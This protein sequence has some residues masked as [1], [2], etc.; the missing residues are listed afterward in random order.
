MVDWAISQKHIVYT[1]VAAFCAVGIIGLARMNK[2]EFPSFTIKQGVVVGVYPGAT[3]Q[4]VE[5]RLTGRLEDCLL[6]IPEVTRNNLR[7]V[8]KDGM[9]FIYTDLNC[10]VSEKNEVWGRIKQKI[11]EQKVSL[12]AGVLAVM[13]LDDFN[14]QSSMMI[15][16]ESSDKGY[17]ELQDYA[18]E[19]CTALRR[20]PELAKVQVLGTQNEEIAVILDREKLSEYGIDPSVLTLSWQ[21]ESLPIPGG[22]FDSAEATAPIHVWGNL[23][24]ENEVAEK[25]VYADPLG[26]LIRLKDIATITRRFEA[27]DDFVSFNGHSCLILSVE[28]RPNHDIVAFGEKVHKV[29]DDYSVSLPESV[30]LSCI[31]DQSKI[32]GESVFSFL[33]DLL[34]SMLLVVLVMLTLFPLKSALIAGTGV[35][36]C[37]AI[38]IAIMYCCRMD[39]NTVTLAAL[40]VVL[41]MIVDNSIITMDGYMG[42]LGDGLDRRSAARSSIKELFAP[43]FAATLAISAMLFPIKFLITGYLGDFVKLFP[44]VLAIAMFVSLIYAVTVIPSLELKYIASATPEGDTLVSRLQRRFFNSLQNAYSKAENFCFRHPALTIGTG[45]TV[46]LLGLF[47]FTRLNVQMMPKAARDFFA[48]ELEVEGGHGIDRAKEVADSLTVML[49]SDSRVESVTSFVGS[50]A[51]RFTATY[52]PITPDKTVAQLIVNTESAK[53]TESIIRE[54][55]NSN[56]H[57][58]PDVSIRYKQMDYQDVEAPIV[59]TLK[60]NDREELRSYADSIKSFMMGMDRQLKWIHSTADNVQPVFRVELDDYEASRLGVNK[61]AL[62]LSMSGIY[63]GQPLATVWEGDKPIGVNLYTEGVGPDMNYSQIGSVMVPTA[64]PGVSVP[65][66]QVASI[67]PDWTCRNLEK[68]SGEET[69]SI[70]ADLKYGE[71]QPKAMKRI[72]SYVDSRIIPVLPEGVSVEYGGLTESNRKLRPEIAWSLAAA[73]LILLVFMIFH[74]KKVSL[75]ILTLLMSLLCLFGAFFGLWLFGLDFGITS[76]LGLISLI[77]IIVRNGIVMYE[78]AEELRF[79]NG[80]DVKSA[81]MEAGARRMKPI[82]LTSCTTALGVIPMVVGGDLLW[83]PMAVVIFFGI[84]FSI[85][86]IV[87]IMPVS[88]WQ[89]FKNDKTPVVTNE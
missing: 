8:S 2:D 20:I 34:V 48:I 51:P 45:I 23:G 81:A 11:N 7:S 46:V 36:I 25:I 77:G 40:I 28:M 14:S 29:L 12:P 21:S 26:N 54:Y 33:G 67:E 72:A 24:S 69:I 10:P 61:A 39:L 52:A 63:G 64:I 56:E 44:W 16:L 84:L 43:T 41:G 32:V 5:D 73:I 15:A 53:A 60:G 88:Y 37:T 1:L 47:L 70:F 31:T 30:R 76:V 71:S 22:T 75:S 19:L 57:I 17:S 66:R 87:L 89:L 18:D 27:P 35:P 58:F 82:F 86:L 3:A 6:G 78:Y 49:K 65:L 9:C 13:V 74:F 85:L 55:E 83:Q 59:V 80:Y 38:T 50:G 42:K 79:K 68:R 62:A 4:E